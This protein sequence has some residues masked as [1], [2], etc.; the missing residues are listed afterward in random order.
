MGTKHIWQHWW[1]N[2]ETDTGLVTGSSIRALALQVLGPYLKP[3]YYKKK[4]KK[5]NRY[6]TLLNVIIL[7]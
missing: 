6:N 3:H 7:C 1:W 5:R 2:Q 4:K